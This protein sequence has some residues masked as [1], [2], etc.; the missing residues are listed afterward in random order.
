[1]FKSLTWR[2][3][4]FESEGWLRCSL[5]E[6]IMVRFLSICYVCLNTWE[7]K[8]TTEGFSVFFFLIGFEQMI[9]SHKS[10]G[11]MLKTPNRVLIFQSIFQRS[12]IPPP[13]RLPISQD[14]TNTRRQR[15]VPE[16]KWT[17]FGVPWATKY[18]SHR[19]RYQLSSVMDWGKAD[20]CPPSP[21]NEP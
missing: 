16:P 1:M 11:C 15:E 17:V 18:H 14:R 7:M 19:G 5:Y 13:R 21:P 12:Q 4:V 20:H 9:S 3:F 2:M 10:Y 8:L 6:G